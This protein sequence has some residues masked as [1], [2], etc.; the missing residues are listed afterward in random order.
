MENLTITKEKVL[1]A[2]SKCSTAKETLKVLFPEVFETEDNNAFIRKFEYTP[3]SLKEFII[4]AFGGGYILDIL[5]S[6]TPEDRSDLRGRAIF[7][8]SN[9]IVK[10][11]DA[12]GGGTYIEITKK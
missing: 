3:Q 2:A 12:L 10:T 8:S 6:S 4:E 7:V 1:E 5:M 11:G 9:Y